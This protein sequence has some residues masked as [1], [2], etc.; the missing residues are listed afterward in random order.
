MQ[1]NRDR[2]RQ[3]LRNSEFK[4]LL[5]EELGWNRYTGEVVTE[6]RE[7][8]VDESEYLLTA[9]AEK[10][11]MA[12]FLCSA[13]ADG[14][15]PDHATRRKIQREAAKSVRENLIIYTD[16]EQ[17]TQIWQ[18]VKQEQGKP[19]ACREHRYGREQSGESLI[20]KLE[21]IAFSLEE[22]DDLTLPDVTGRVRAAF[23]VERV[24]K[25]FYDRFKREHNQFL[26]FL[27]GI[28]DQEMERWY[29]SVMLN[30]LMFI[31][32]IQKKG[33]LNNDPD[34]LRTRLTENQLRGN[35]RYYTDFLCP[36]F[37]E[38]FAKPKSERSREMKRLLGEVPYLNGGI[39]QRH[40]IE[41]LHGKTIQ[42]ADAAF[43]ELFNFFEAY[44]WHLDE[45][46]L[47]ND[48]EINPDVLGYI[49]E[50]YINQKQMGAY[51]TKEDITEYIS[52]NT[53]I[54]SLFDV[55]RNR[56]RIAFEGEASVWQLLQANPDRYIYDAIK[57]GIELE[58][59]E[60]IAA[61]INDL[62][63]RAIW[64][65]GAPDEYALPTETWREVVARRSRYEVVRS[66]LSN[67]KIDDI[68]ALITYNLDIRQF[69]QDVIEN[70]EGPELLRAFWKAI[71]EV[72][73]L[74]PTCGSGAFLF[75]A[76]NILEPLY[77]AC[78]D[79]MEVFLGE[80]EHTSE[81][82]HTQ[83][84][85]DFRNELKSIEQHPNRR[86]FILKLIIINNL[87]GV[88][89]MEEAIEICKLRLFLKMVAQIDD[90]R[91]IEPL[92]DIDFNIQAGNTLVGYTTYDE[93]EKAVT[94]NR[95]DFDNTMQRIEERAEDVQKLFEEFQRQQTEEG[96]DVTPADKQV[97]RN[98]I[99]E[100]EHE[101]NQFLADEYGID[102]NEQTDYQSWLSSHKPFHWFVE[103]YGI[104]K[105]GGFNVIIGNPPYV[106]IRK[107]DY[108]SSLEK[109]LKL[110]DLYGYVLIRT[111]DLSS[112]NGRNGMI[113][114]LS[115]AFSRDFP[116][117]R[118]SL[119]TEGI[120]W[121][122]SFDNGPSS[123]F[124]GVSQRCTIW[125][126]CKCRTIERACFSSPMYRW[127]SITR[128]YLI[129][130]ISY[131]KIN[132]KNN[133]RLGIPKIHNTALSKV[134]DAIDVKIHKPSQ[135]VLAL[136][137][138][139]SLSL[140]FSPTARNFISVFRSVPPCLDART[141][142]LV[143]SSSTPKI[144]L[145]IKTNINS[146]LAVL[147]GETFFW[148]WL[149]RGD[150]FHVTAGDVSN[151]LKVL[152]KLSLEYQEYLG[153]LGLCLYNRRYE[154]LVFKKNAGKYVGSFNYRSQFPIT[155]RSDLL[156][157]AGLDLDKNT[158]LT[159]FDNVQRILAINEFAGEKS[160][161]Q[162]VKQKFPP[163]KI[164]SNLESDIFAQVDRLIVDHYNF[165]DEELDFI[166]N[167]DIKY[168]RGLGDE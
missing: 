46:P 10:R 110:P 126:G 80:L 130:R 59:P 122:S 93:V 6:I 63:K 11:G 104:L 119:Y 4:S 108:T 160:I 25:R 28:P 78:L 147:L 162:A 118:E 148:Y 42:I 43:E 135:R 79:R 98:K 29:A 154:A 38:G 141:L 124:A 127:R 74:D 64:N 145:H 83:R 30:R 107:I 70:C 68:N 45:R 1:I 5:V 20:Q 102:L 40:Q 164:D 152:E 60:D 22:E 44:Q 32:F 75:A 144:N 138:E 88:D 72:T 12:V 7:T 165:T 133:K 62:S 48:N 100:L 21:T 155:R 159:I 140:Y 3:L 76:L 146:A 37:F 134:L 33:F 65:E 69:A 73:I 27:E 115:I 2:I 77:E 128:T 151:F 156:L 91:Q 8:V 47:R 24:T 89:I 96:G 9:I 13:R 87:Y 106:S 85:R 111:L 49:F 51:Y 54:P 158:A 101:L 53:I 57:T 34:Y 120:S 109:R 66:K 113:V 56:C 166:I 41:E 137:K 26:N 132:W 157:L 149:V 86:Y 95:I 15:I 39:F 92:P 81:N 58:L 97:L 168:R 16:T 71:T 18:W 163:L 139:T 90:A 31:Y 17:T 142:E 36:L 131:V 167:H 103:F 61:G 129:D 125:I 23:D 116:I 114:P 14:T 52:K 50:K 94:E 112:N 82:P 35:D 105:D 121:F 19:L 84:F 117:L 143:S 150:G 136:P 55:A 99:K 153:M 161:P 123:I 67:G